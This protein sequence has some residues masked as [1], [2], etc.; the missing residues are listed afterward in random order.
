MLILPSDIM[1]ED[2]KFYTLNALGLMLSFMG[3]GLFFYF[4]SLFIPSSVHQI[5]TFVFLILG[6]LLAQNSLKYHLYY[7]FNSTL[8][9]LFGTFFILTRAYLFL[10]YPVRGAFVREVI[11]TAIAIAFFLSIIRLNDE[12]KPHILRWIMILSI[13]STLLLFIVF[14]QDPSSVGERAA[15][16]FDEESGGNPQ[17]Y[18]RIAFLGLIA[19]FVKLQFEDLSRFKRLALKVI[20]IIS[21][22]GIVI[23]RVRTTILAVMFLSIF[24]VQLYGLRKLINNLFSLRTLLYGGLLQAFVY[25]FYEIN[26][27]SLFLNFLDP[28]INFTIKALDTAFSFGNSENID[29]SANS[30]VELIKMAIKHLENNPL[31]LILGGGYRFMYL[32]VPLMEVLVSYGLGGFFHFLFA[33]GV[34]AYLS[35]KAVYSKE[36]FQVFLGFLFIYLMITQF[37][38]G[39]TMEISFLLSMCLIIRYLDVNNKAKRL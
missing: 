26:L 23:T 15:I 33:M 28:V 9:W 20:F 31:D 6:I 35:F 1:L 24:M 29:A 8:A 27:F 34:G 25:L 37:T 12:L 7:K 36:S 16:K 32:D 39:V 21:F 18:S 13:G 14:Y 38:Q 11:S 19:S 10:Y 2:K 3:S 4:R 22:L 5:S 30:R 17:I